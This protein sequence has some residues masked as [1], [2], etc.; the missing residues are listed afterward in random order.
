MGKVTAAGTGMPDLPIVFIPH[1]VDTLAEQEIWSL[2]DEAIP[3]IVRSLT[4]P[5]RAAAAEGAPGKKVF[6]TELAAQAGSTEAINRQF[7]ERGWTDGLPITPPTRRAVEAMLAFT[8]R[9]PQEVLAT[10]PPRGGSATVEKVAV[11][12]VMAGCVPEYFPLVLTAVE[13]MAEEKDINLRGIVTTTA[14][15]TLA[16][17]INGP[18]RKE[19]EVN[20]GAGCLGSGWRA[21]AAIGRAVRL[22]VLNIAGGAPG[23][24]DKSTLGHPGKYALCFAENEEAS[25]WQPL[26]VEMGLARDTSAVTL[27]TPQ[28]LVSM[29]ELASHTGKGVLTTIAH[30]M[31]HPAGG[32]IV[33]SSPEPFVDAGRPAVILPPEFAAMAAKDGLSKDDVKDFLWE[34]AQMPYTA[35]GGEWEMG[36]GRFRGEGSPILRVASRASEIMIAVAG[37]PGRQAAY[38]PN[39]SRP[40]TKPVVRRDGTPVRSVYDFR[41]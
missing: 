34:R 3:G 20:A 1:P 41:K 6:P 38:F 21:N 25:P 37:G 5:V 13:A 36:R 24:V 7:Y 39:F 2:V 40:V 4:S 27:F 18:L 8:D 23:I 19:L 15:T 33:R 29:C 9:A 31:A 32:N 14:P 12:A 11:N 28:G 16:V 35:I 17:M 26:H 22:I 30:S 10:L